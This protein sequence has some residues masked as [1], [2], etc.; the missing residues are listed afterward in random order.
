MA[1]AVE[2]HTLNGTVEK[3][4]MTLVTSG[5]SNGV[6]WKIKI[7]HPG[8]NK[9]VYYGLLEYSDGGGEIIGPFSTQ[10]TA[11]KKI[12]ALAAKRGSSKKSLSGFL[13]A[14]TNNDRDTI[15]KSYGS[16]YQTWESVTKAP[17][18]NTSGAAG[19]YLIPVEYS[20]RMLDKMLDFAIIKPRAMVIPMGSAQNYCP[21]VDAETLTGTAGATSLF[22]GVQFSWGNQEVPLETEPLFR[23]TSLYSWD[24]LGYAKVSNQWLED[25]TPRADDYLTTIFAGAAN[26]QAEY[27]YFNGQG[28]NSTMPLGIIA[29]PGTVLVS[30]KTSGHVTAQDLAVMV[31]SLLPYSIINAIWCCSPTAYADL[32]QVTG[33]FINATGL[34]PDGR[35]FTIHGR[36]GYITDKLPALGGTGDLVLFDP[37]LYAI[38]ERQEVLVEK[39]SMGAGFPT[40]QTY[41]RVW[42]RGDGKPM[43]GN[44]IKL[45]DNST[46]VG[47]YVALV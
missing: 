21:R 41:F 32:S 46:V 43:V 35:H 30:R 3:S 42:L 5:E 19:G 47:A 27:A 26:W 38:G 24:L 15:E 36:P 31:G 33:W 16:G 8:T 14:V 23:Q 1:T 39:S 25:T 45:Q 10:T 44:T 13:H 22:G 37:S 20:D 40:N 6:A 17:M 4:E 28:A 7:D 9:A 2:R 29:A 11:A 34:E 12:E 18:G